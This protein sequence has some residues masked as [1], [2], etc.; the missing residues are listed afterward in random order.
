MEKNKTLKLSL[1]YLYFLISRFAFDEELRSDLAVKL[2]AE[3]K[4]EMDFT[5]TINQIEEIF[6][7]EYRKYLSV[8][9]L[10]SSKIDTDL[11]E[12]ILRS[13]MKSSEK[14]IMA[15]LCLSWNRHDIARKLIFNDEYR[16]DVSSLFFTDL[17][18]IPG[19][20]K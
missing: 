14:K 9:E 10:D 17:L 3:L 11:D 4:K 12:A 7:P 6:K 16:E 5:S 8:F 13:F 2:K 19:C 1:N 20:K 15:E 18:C